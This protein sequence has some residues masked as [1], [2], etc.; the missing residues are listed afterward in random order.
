M[1]K[2]IILSFSL[3]FLT[4]Q[5]IF[6]QNPVKLKRADCFFGV[7]LD[8][9]ATEE[10][11]NAGESLTEMMIDTFLTKVKPDFIQIDC[12]GHPGITSYP[13]KVG[14]SVK[15]FQKDPLRL[16]RDVTTKHNVGLYGRG[17]PPRPFSRTKSR[18]AHRSTGRGAGWHTGPSPCAG[19]AIRARASR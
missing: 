19:A 4:A 5:N 1:K 2:L 13:T 7:H 14:Y 9:H 8:L 15:G 17:P 18:P 16:F 11:T 12:K 10:I 3:F 6:A